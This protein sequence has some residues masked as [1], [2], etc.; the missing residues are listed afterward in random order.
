M[1]LKNLSIRKYTQSNQKFLYDT[2]LSNLKPK[3]SFLSHE[4]NL[5]TIS[6]IDVR[7]MFKLA[8]E[9]TN[10][11]VSIKDLFLIAYDVSEEDFW[12]APIVDGFSAKAFIIKFLNDTQKKE[13]KL[14]KSIG[15]QNDKWAIAGGDRLNVFSDLMPLVQI[16]E[17]YGIYPFDLQ[18]KPYN[19][20]LTLLVV[21]KTKMEV[22]NKYNELISKK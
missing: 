3:N 16:G 21:H 11:I 14:L 9:S 12:N 7:K 6:Y 13:E 18:H 22:Q 10:D 5:N 8:K 4:I 19:E 17:I 2:L 15:V 1:E 20:I